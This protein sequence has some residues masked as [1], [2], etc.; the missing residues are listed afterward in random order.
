MK[1]KNDIPH[2]KGCTT[3]P[4]ALAAEV[5]GSQANGKPSGRKQPARTVAVKRTPMKPKIYIAHRDLSV[6]ET[7]KM[8]GVSK[9]RTKELIELA[10]ELSRPQTP[11]PLKSNGQSRARKHPVR[12]A[13]R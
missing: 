7:A 8:V 1:P 10:T 3:K 2:E 9:R 11:R 13:N 12:T 5:N 4:V 6:E